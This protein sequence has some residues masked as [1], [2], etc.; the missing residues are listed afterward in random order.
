MG[1]ETTIV[2]ALRIDDPHDA[3]ALTALVHEQYRR[4]HGGQSI[5][6]RRADGLVPLRAVRWDKLGPAWRIQAGNVVVLR[7]RVYKA[8]DSAYEEYR[9]T[10]LSDSPPDLPVPFPPDVPTPLALSM[11]TAA[12]VGFRWPLQVAREIQSPNQNP[13]LEASRG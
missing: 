4:T 5:R 8:G 3:E 9:L 1:V 2:I 13:N 12:V 10:V 7:H 6:R 11:L